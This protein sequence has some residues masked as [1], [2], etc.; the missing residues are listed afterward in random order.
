MA[1]LG[2]KYGN[3]HVS[4]WRVHAPASWLLGFTAMPFHTIH[5]SWICGP[6]F[7]YLAPANMYTQ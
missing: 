6:L 2:G 4:C 1:A 7:K 3:R 5:D